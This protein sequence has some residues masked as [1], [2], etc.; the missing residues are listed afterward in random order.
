MSNCSH[1]TDFAWAAYTISERCGSC[2]GRLKTYNPYTTY[3]SA[4]MG[5]FKSILSVFLLGV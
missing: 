1:D 5:W 4:I 2:M 3:D